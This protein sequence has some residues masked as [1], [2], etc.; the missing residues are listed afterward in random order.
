HRRKM[1]ADRAAIGFANLAL[2]V[3]IVEFIGHVPVQPHQMA[4]LGA[5]RRE[6]SN[7]IFQRLLDLGN[8]IVA[9][10]LRARVPADLTGNEHLPAL[11]G[12]AVGVTFRRC[13]VFRLNDFERAFAHG[14]CSRNLKRWI[15]PVCVFGKA[16]TNLTTRGY[17]YG[18][19]VALTWSCKILTR[20]LSA[21]TPAFSTT[22][23]ATTCPRSI[24]AVP[25]P[26]PPS[27]AGA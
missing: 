9:L 22:K 23:A 27:T 3:D 5:G 16:S 21:T 8:E 14:A 7:D 10:E 19:M 26:A 24:S 15:F 12:D 13:P 25:S 4:W 11:R 17:L 20:R 18:A 6:Y 1:P 2:A